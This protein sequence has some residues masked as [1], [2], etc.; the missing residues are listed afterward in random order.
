MI[1][2]AIQKIIVGDALTEAEMVDT[3]NEIMEGKTTDAQIA[4]FL[5][6]LRL[7]GETIEE[8]TGAA[9]VMRDKATPIQTKHALVVDTCS[10]GGSGLHSF[11]ISTTSAFVVAG[12]GVP[13]AKHGNR[14]VTR[15]SGSANVLMALGVNIEISP[16]HV[17]QCIDEVGIGF[18]FAPVL[19][20]AMKYAIGPRREIGIRTIFN[21]VAPLTNPAKA[22]AQVLGVYAPELTESHA[23]ALNN[24]GSQHAFVVHGNDGLDEITTTTTT[25]VSELANGTVKTYTLDP[26]D[27]GIPKAEPKML[28]GGTP[29]ENAE[30]S[31]GILMG[32]KG[33]KRDI[34]VLN[35]GAAIVAG[36]KADNL[37]AGVELATKSIDSGDALAKLEAL[38]SKS[39]S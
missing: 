20:G 24:F 21:T 8:I 17:G 5:T 7:K 15:Q 29:E 34:V 26:A 13:V 37:D 33:P 18:L 19:H 2:E 35:A 1:R 36:G 4:C 12:A 27:F 11:N 9:R 22:R 31:L 30:M 23:N 14:G 25:R 10:T 16:E 32:N 6:A 28:L 39:N 3:M 38:K